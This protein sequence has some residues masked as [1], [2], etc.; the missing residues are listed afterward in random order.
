MTDLSTTIDPKSDQLNSDDLIAGPRTITVT[1]VVGNSGKDQPVS[2]FFEGDRGKPYMPCKSMRRVL[3]HL[4]GKDG[5]SYAG[6]SMTLYRDPSVKFGGI[7]VGGIRISHMSHI[8][9]DVS[10]MLTSTRG[11]RDPYSVRKLVAQATNNEGIEAVR[12]IQSATSLA[13]LEALTPVITSI[14]DRK[15]IPPAEFKML[16]ERYTEKQAQL[17]AAAVP[18]SDTNGNI[19]EEY[20]E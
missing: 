13:E 14:R 12:A 15:A 4:W 20:G 9:A 16:R 7:E 17:K 10:L 18:V 8:E 11:K 19:E 2:I 3:V 6:K 1:R 5:S